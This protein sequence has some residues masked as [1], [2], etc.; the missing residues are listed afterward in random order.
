MTKRFTQLTTSLEP[1]RTTLVWR[2][3]RSELTG[4]QRGRHVVTLSCL[5]PLPDHV[6]RSVQVDQQHPLSNSVEQPVAVVTLQCRAGQHQL[7]LIPEQFVQAQQP[8]PTVL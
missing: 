3:K 1:Q 2:F 8:G 6:L 7:P 4:Q 5:Q